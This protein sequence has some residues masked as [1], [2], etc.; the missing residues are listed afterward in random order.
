VIHYDHYCFFLQKTIGKENRK[1]FFFALL[2]NFLAV[3]LF[4]VLC[5]S[6]LD[7]R[8]A[9]SGYLCT[10]TVRLFLQFW[11][12]NIYLKLSIF[13]SLSVAWYNFCYLF[14]VCL[15]ISQGLTLNEL[16]N[17][18]RYRYLYTPYVALDD[19]VKMEFKNPYNKGTLNNILDFL[20][21]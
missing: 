14:I 2:T 13:I 12:L 21:N 6:M 19:T 1:V 4:L 7:D 9:P 5:W 18:N 15:S 11:Q 10:Y 17:R 16:L 20:L 8:V 3:S